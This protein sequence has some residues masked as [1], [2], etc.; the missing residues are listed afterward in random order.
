MDLIFM[1]NNNFWIEIT[2]PWEY[3]SWLSS[4]KYT[5]Y[6]AFLNSSVFPAIDRL[7]EKELIVNYHFLNHKD[8]NGL[9]LQKQGPGGIDIRLLVKDKSNLSIIQ[10][11]L[12]EFG[13][14]TKVKDYGGDHLDT[15]KVLRLITEIV[16]IT[17]GQEI[18]DI[19]EFFLHQQ[20]YQKKILKE[21]SLSGKINNY[22]GK[23]LDT[24]I[25]RKLISDIIKIT[26]SQTK[27]PN[28]MQSF[29]LEQQH[30]Q[31]NAI[32]MTQKD[33]REFLNLENSKNII[34][35]HWPA[36]KAN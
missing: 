23:F 21:A 12:K 31:N 16:R 14:P 36:A 9:D 4:S 22:P 1:T 3:G 18:K 34:Q 33:E 25:I 19:K 20:Q 6:I 27:F 11:I 10:E 29:F 5:A 15:Q 35:Q 2:V 8:E 13:L 26:I 30:Y 17:I 7:R 32:G 24:P 28:D